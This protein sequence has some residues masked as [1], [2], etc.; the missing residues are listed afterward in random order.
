MDEGRLGTEIGPADSITPAA[1]IA[2]V[3]EAR[4]RR[5]RNRPADTSGDGSQ[6]AGPGSAHRGPA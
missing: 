1:F 5:R 4:A 3:Q 2:N 6:H